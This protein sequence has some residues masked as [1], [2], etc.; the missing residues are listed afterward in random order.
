MECFLIKKGK[1]SMI[2]TK[3]EYS[4]N[5]NSKTQ[6]LHDYSLKLIFNYTKNRGG[7]S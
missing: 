5:N 4:N 6:E 7:R 2:I 3:T 1:K